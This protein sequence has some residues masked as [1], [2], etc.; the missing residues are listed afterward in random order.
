MKTKTSSRRPTGYGKSLD[1]PSVEA[2]APLSGADQLLG[3]PGGTAGERGITSFDM[4]GDYGGNVF[5][6][7]SKPVKQ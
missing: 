6:C 1:S 5:G 2:E 7:C 4:D 3:D